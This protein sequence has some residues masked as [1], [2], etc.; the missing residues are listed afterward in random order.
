[1]TPSVITASLGGYDIGWPLPPQTATCGFL[2]FA[3]DPE[4]FWPGARHA[5]P[6][7]L[8]KVPKCRPDLYTNCDVNIWVDGSFEVTSAR[9]VEWCVQQLGDND[10]AM[11][12][13]PDR[14]SIIAE[15]E[16][17]APMT[18][19]QGHPV[20]EQAIHYMSLGYDGTAGLWATG[21]IVSRATERI[22]MLGDAWLREQMRWTW[23]DQISLP[24]LLWA[25]GIEPTPLPGPLL[26]NSMFRYHH[27]RR[28]D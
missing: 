23:Q 22:R 28:E 25:G 15:A 7:M 18:K 6:R 24:V 13:H 20:R 19:Y 8:A 5:H 17:S 21:I 9:F 16:V 26:G 10:I 12:P 4:F 3:D 27:H 1:M 2:R 11:F 14:Q